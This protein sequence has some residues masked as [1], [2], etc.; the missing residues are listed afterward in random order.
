MIVRVR[1]VLKKNCCSVN[2]LT[3][4]SKDYFQLLTQESCIAFLKQ[5]PLN[6]CQQIPVPYK[7][8]IND[9]NKTEKQASNRP[10]DNGRIETNQWLL[11]NLKRV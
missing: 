2:C 3:A 6:R 5:T 1:V 9:V 10:A 4:C 8:L 11:A 7:P